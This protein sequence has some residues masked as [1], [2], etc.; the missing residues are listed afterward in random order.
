MSN[1]TQY[2]TKNFIDDL[3]YVQNR[4]SIFR[5]VNMNV[6]LMFEITSRYPCIGGLK[7]DVKS[8]Y[9]D[10]KSIVF[11]TCDRRYC[12][13]GCG[14]VLYVNMLDYIDYLKP[15]MAIDIEH[16]VNHVQLNIQKISG[17]TV[18]CIVRKAGIV[19]RGARVCLPS[20]KYCTCPE[21]LSKEMIQDIKFAKSCKESVE[22]L[23]M[24]KPLDFS[25]TK[26]VKDYIK[27]MFNPSIMVLAK[28]RPSDVREM[29]NL[30]CLDEY[31]GIIYKNI[32]TQYYYT[33]QACMDKIEYHI[34]EY[35]YQKRKAIIMYPQLN[36][37]KDDFLPLQKSEQDAFFL[38]PDCFLIGQD[39]CYEYVYWFRKILQANYDKC[40]YQAANR[41]NNTLTTEI[42]THLDVLMRKISYATQICDISAIVMTSKTGRSI[43]KLTHF[44]P[45]CPIIVLTHDTYVAKKLLLYNN[46]HSILVVRNDNCE[47]LT[48]EQWSVDTYRTM[49]YG[50][51]YGLQNQLLAMGDNVLLCYRSNMNLTYPDTSTIRQVVPEMFEDEKIESSSL[52]SEEMLL[53]VSTH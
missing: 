50:I 19:M 26:A 48:Q 13:K 49:I 2:A 15:Y 21:A 41:L 46:V 10:K 24:P 6:S 34:F 52:K 16:K 37:D 12:R 20:I 45:I 33:I 38:Y 31:D 7:N 43:I 17:I 40:K 47:L 42:I 44:R 8:V 3:N 53:N 39:H 4:L 29:F 35:C 1:H 22:I 18:K 9:L 36:P 11:I 28:V 51:Y 14:T 5:G 32:S 23:V 30:E 27:P 25:N